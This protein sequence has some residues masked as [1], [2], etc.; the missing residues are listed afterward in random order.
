MAR[1]NTT[2]RNLNLVLGTAI[3]A[4]GLGILW[5]QPE[6]PAGCLTSL[7]CSAAN[8]LAE[9]LPCLV[10]TACQVLGDYAFDHLLSSAYPLHHL[11]SFLPLLKVFAG[12]A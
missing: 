12:A 7:L 4:F 3:A 2:A 8:G 5:A 11:I 6:G 1:Q 9:L 10:R